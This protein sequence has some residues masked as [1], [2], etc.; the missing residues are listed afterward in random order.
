[1]PSA[2]NST[3]A[4]A[5]ATISQP[6]TGTQRGLRKKSGIS[7]GTHCCS[8]YNRSGAW[9]ADISSARTLW[10]S[11]EVGTAD[12][13]LFDE[14]ERDLAPMV[15]QAPRDAVGGDRRGRRQ[16]L[17]RRQRL[18]VADDPG[19]DQDDYHQDVHD[20]GGGTVE[21]VVVLGDELADLVE[22]QPEPDSTQHNGTGSGPRNPASS[23]R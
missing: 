23:I 20:F 5:P 18:E 22:E 14:L 3:P 21:V 15:R 2:P 6:T 19:A 8:R 17:L 9:S 13:G 10:T 12:P 11:L 1:M 16:A 4:S 7:R